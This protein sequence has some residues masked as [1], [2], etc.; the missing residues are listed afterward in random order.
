MGYFH[1]Q[2]ICKSD[3]R[4]W[5]I[6]GADM[7]ACD[8]QKLKQGDLDNRYIYL[9]LKLWFHCLNI[10]E[11]HPDGR[12]ALGYEL[13]DGTNK[14]FLALTQQVCTSHS[15]QHL[16]F[17]PC[18]SLVTFPSICLF[19]EEANNFC[20]TVYSLMCVMPDWPIYPAENLCT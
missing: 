8:L 2:Y 5:E 10:P 9:K 14:W 11:S 15:C 4:I 6:I 12:T 13:I 1:K 7:A 3:E 18:I 17:A 20:P 16:Y 19:A